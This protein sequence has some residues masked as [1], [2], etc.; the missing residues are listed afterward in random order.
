M[1]SLTAAR[2]SGGLAAPTPPRRGD[3]AGRKRLGTKSAS[4]EIMAGS[5][6]KRCVYME[7]VMLCLPHGL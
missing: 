2:R 5:E 6:E 1:Q 3:L 4:V 7:D